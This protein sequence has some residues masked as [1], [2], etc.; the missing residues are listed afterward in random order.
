MIDNTVCPTCK[1][2]K[3]P[4]SRRCATC[5]VQDGGRYSRYY[6]GA[7]TKD[8]QIESLTVRVRDLEAALRE[9]ANKENWGCVNCAA[10][11]S[12]THHDRQMWYDEDNGYEVAQK[13][14]GDTEGR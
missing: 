4:Q 9:Y 14:L 10:N 5:Y 1:G 12:C 7:G 8:Q 13:A 6:H 2:V 11:P 3:S